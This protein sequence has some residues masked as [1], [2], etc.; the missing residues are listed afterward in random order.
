MNFR[1]LNAKHGYHCQTPLSCHEPAQTLGFV[2][3]VENPVRVNLDQIGLSARCPLPP[4][5]ATRQRTS[6][7]VSNVPCVDGSELARRIFT[8]Q[9]W[10]VLPFVR[11]IDVVH[12][13]AG[14]NALRGSGPGQNRA[15]DDAMAQ[16]GLS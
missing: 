7:D 8:S 10:S 13:T 6:R 12:M 9:A 4:P 15:F 14:H 11:P 3:S 16:I 2:C 1:Y 5:L